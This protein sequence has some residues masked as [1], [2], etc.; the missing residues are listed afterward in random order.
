MSVSTSRLELD[1][2]NTFIKWRLRQA[3][4]TLQSGRWLTADFNADCLRQCAH[5]PA[6]VWL[7]SVAGAALNQRLAA[8]VRECWGVELQQAFT[9]AQ[10]AGVSNSYS[11][12]SRMGVDRWLA[13]LA[14]W[15][16]TRG[17]CCVVDAGS[18]ITVDVLDDRGEHQGGYI[19]PGLRLMQTSLLGRTA[20]IR[21]EDALERVALSPGRSTE[22][23]VSHGAHLLMLA[24]AERV[25]KGLPGQKGSLPVLV[26]GGD[27]EALL[28]YLSQAQHH[29][30][31][32]L[33]G[34][35]WTLG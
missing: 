26:T 23:A 2:G 28:P 6:S 18:A 34:L 35:Q 22:E 9:Q 16:H 10:C 11:D 3:G 8:A 31:L 27:A 15:Q 20:E 7:G 4:V 30:D 32:V 5:S 19:L 29:P 24:L 14:A 21:V 13:M 25:D 33:D 1:A 12:P 17:A